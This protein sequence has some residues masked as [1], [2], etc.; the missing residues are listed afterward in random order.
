MV[1]FDK[2]KVKYQLIT[3]EA[4]SKKLADK[5]KNTSLF[6]FDTETDA[7]DSFK[8]KLAGVAFST[9][10]G[11]GYF[12]AV[13]PFKGD[14]ELFDEDLSDRIPLDTFKKHFQ[15]IFADKKIKKV[16]Q[17]GKFDISVLRSVGMEVNNFYFDTMLAGYVLDP[18]Q[19]LSMDELS[20]KYLKYK[21]IP[22]SD[23]IGEKK[24]PSK[25]FTV[26]PETLS[27]YSAEDA[28][29]TFRLYEVLDKE[30]KKSEQIDVAYKIEFPLAPVLEHMENEGIK[31]DKKALNS[32]S[33]DMQ[34]LLDN[35][36]KEIYK[37][38]GEEFNINSTKQ[39]QEILY[40]KLGLQ[41]GRKT[42]TGYST[43][44]RALEALRGEHDIINLI[45]DYRQV[46]KLKST[47][48]DALPNL[49]NSKTGRVHTTFNQ[50]A[51]STGRLS[52]NDPNLQNIPIRTDLGKEIRKAFIP[53]DKD[54]VILSADYS[55]VELRIMASICGDEGLIK[56]FQKS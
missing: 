35:Y 26:E 17:N 34:I 12:I 33:K 46:S 10:S 13:N 48:V 38:S 6:V 50:T 20:K 1:V 14:Q 36:T 23:L 53:R 9:K 28:D 55:Q 44:A 22:L 8:L 54:H 41:S 49:I 18:D 19:K 21:P 52:S 16:C 29:I 15:K 42:K 27:H 25:I 51:A 37:Q 40:N 39:L 4:E 32:M 7:L 24:D 2:K 30:L 11:E 43:D 45:L 47:Y 56:A 5:L 3:T 31:I